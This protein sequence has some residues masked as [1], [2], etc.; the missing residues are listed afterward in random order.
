MSLPV[1]VGKRTIGRPVGWRKPNANRMSIM[2]RLSDELK[3]W[4]VEESDLNNLSI[5]EI[6]RQCLEDRMVDIVKKRKKFRPR[7]RSTK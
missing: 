2:I 3:T 1:M 7:A 4:L 6:A 5:S